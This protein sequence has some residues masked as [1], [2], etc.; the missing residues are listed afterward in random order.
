MYVLR[1]LIGLVFKSIRKGIGGG[2][3]EVAL[4]EASEEILR[5]EERIMRVTKDD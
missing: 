4:E 1:G 5:N 2:G 3:I